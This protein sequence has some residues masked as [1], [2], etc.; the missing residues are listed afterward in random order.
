MIIYLFYF[1]ENYNKFYK[2]AKDNKSLSEFKKKIIKIIRRKQIKKNNN[3][4]KDLINNKN[5][6][7]KYNESCKNVEKR[8]EDIVLNFLK[9]EIEINGT[10]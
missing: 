1:N 7:V 5:I 4:T 10:V 6:E 8:F 9:S 2:I 3:K